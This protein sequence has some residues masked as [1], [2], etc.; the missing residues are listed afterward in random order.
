MG[1]KTGQKKTA[2]YHNDYSPRYQSPYDIYDKARNHMRE[3][4]KGEA[5]EKKRSDGLKTEKK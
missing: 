4:K 2:H 3:L 5:E 1:E